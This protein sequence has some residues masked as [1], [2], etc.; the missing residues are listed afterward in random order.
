MPALAE[1]R[2]DAG[3]PSQ[4]RLD[5]TGR[6]RRIV[7]VDEVWR[8][9]DGWWR[10]QPI[11]RTYFRLALEDGRLVTAYR[12]DVEGTWWTQRY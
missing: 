11:A 3:V 5:G 8:I 6:W 12:D 4:V 2:A 9:D 7:H 10:P 1:V